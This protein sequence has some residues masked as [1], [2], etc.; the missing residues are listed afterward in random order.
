[1]AIA[2]LLAL[3]MAAVPLAHSAL[4]C[5]IIASLAMA[6]AG[7]LYT[8]ATNDMLTFAARGSVPVTT[9][10]TTLTQSLV[11]IIVSPIIG[12]LVELSG[13]YRWVMVGAGL[14][15][16]PGCFFWLIHASFYKPP[17]KVGRPLADLVSDKV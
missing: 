12:K 8:L 2:T 5:V 7:G 13:N 17:P 15:V 6:G 4:P 9:G 14:W 3:L 16:L 10:L 11:Y 1:M